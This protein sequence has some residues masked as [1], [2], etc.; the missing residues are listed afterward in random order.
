M[1]DS[2]G[3]LEDSPMQSME[4]RWIGPCRKE[5]I[6]KTPFEAGFYKKITFSDEE[7]V[8]TLILLGY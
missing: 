8:I 7:M 3:N 5:K 4:Q 2:E 6:I 1:R